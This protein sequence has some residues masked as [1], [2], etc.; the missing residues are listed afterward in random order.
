MSFF[1]I[2]KHIR[3]QD[4]LDVL[5]LSIITYYLYVWFRDT[6][7]FRALIGLLAL[8][9]IYTAARAWG[10]F[11]TTWMFQ[12]LWQVLII[13]LIILFQS[14][15]RQVLERFNPMKT[16]GWRRTPV[17]DDWEDQLAEACFDLSER[18]IG[19]I[20]IVE[21][22]HRVDELVT[23]GVPLEAPPTREIL[24]SIFE[25]SAPLHDG[26]I[27]VRRGRIV[28]VGCFLPLSSADA[29]P[30]SWGTRH[31]AAIGISE[32]SDAWAVVVSE[33]RGEISVARAGAL[34]SVE[35][36]KMLSEILASAVVQTDPTGQSFQKRILTLLRY[37]WR[38]KL[39][40]LA[41]VVAVWMLLAGQQNF[42]ADL[43]VPI[44]LRH[45]PDGIAL[46][47][48]AKPEIRVTVRGLRKDAS[49]IIPK[50]VRLRLDLSNAVAGT[51]NYRILES[52]VIL[53][54]PQVDV[55]RVDPKELRLVF[56]PK[57]APASE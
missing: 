9:V 46:V 53:P 34:S 1:A 50:D 11:L 31:R 35:N 37:N 49:T 43:Y 57:P 29:I 48:P 45:L 17:I 39:T 22:T 7:A 24:L 56:A 19:A 33:E 27:V 25:K 36:G 40:S 4:F 13:L 32:R 12:I 2:L 23:G 47:E 44:D 21:R 10:L 41:L 30:Q 5:F 54:T 55:V 38:E 18:Q 3:F 42:E 20:V 52:Q 51:F 14:E 8:G 16:V 6:K 15:I 26:A 28:E